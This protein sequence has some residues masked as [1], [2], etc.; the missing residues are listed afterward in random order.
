MTVY[1]GSDGFVELKR[2][3]AALAAQGELNA[4]DVNV[5]RRRFSIDGAE[6]S[7]IIG[8][9]I[10]I[11][12][13]DKSSLVLVS[14]HTDS[15]GEY[16]KDWRGY[17]HVD[18]VGGLRLYNNF[19]QAIKGDMSSALELV[20][21]PEKKDIIIKTQNNKFRGLAEVKSYEFTTSRDQVDITT[22][23]N[24]FRDQYE[25]GLISG[26]GVIDCFWSYG[27]D[28]LE[29]CTDFESEFPIYLARL[30]L[31][32]QQGSD[33]LGRFFLYRADDTSNDASVWY[34]AECIITNVTVTVEPTQIISSSIQFVTTGTVR[35]HQGM[36]PQYLLKEDQGLLLTEG[37]EPIQLEAPT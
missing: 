17:V 3:S 37:G 13:A 35:L 33:F 6:G 25:R 24:E 12:T 28:C 16:H 15:K 27:Y 2:D 31:R 20:K 10:S 29:R 11:I 23:G 36:P 5:D 7:L 19:E 34:E 9:H 14:G 32:L 1:L 30:C 4:A 8:D 22:L 26:Q 18:D 21:P